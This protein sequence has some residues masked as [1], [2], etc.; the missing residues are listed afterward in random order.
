[1]PV[2]ISNLRTFDPDP[3]PCPPG[4]YRL[5]ASCICGRAIPDHQKYDMTSFPSCPACGSKMRRYEPYP[6]GWWTRLRFWW[7]MRQ[8]KKRRQRLYA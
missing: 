8:W 1:M 4:R 5:V 7:Q 2:T 3:K 6:V